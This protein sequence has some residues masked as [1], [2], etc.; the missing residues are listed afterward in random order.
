[1]NDQQGGGTFIVTP[2]T[3]KLQSFGGGQ[4]VKPP[5]S[6]T[7]NQMQLYGS[8]GNGKT[9]AVKV[10][11]AGAIMM[12]VESDI[13]AGQTCIVTIPAVVKYYFLRGVMMLAI[14]LVNEGVAGST[15]EAWDGN[16]QNLR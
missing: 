3:P 11:P 2:N 12:A 1:M 5:D 8:D 16:P 15:V 4:L 13:P 6:T 7:K 14:P 10:T 9:R